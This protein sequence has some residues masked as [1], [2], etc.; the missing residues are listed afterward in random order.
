[1]V[2]GKREEPI[3]VWID[4][5]NIDIDEDFNI[6]M[7]TLF[8]HPMRH[9]FSPISISPTT[10]DFATFP[11][12]DDKAQLLIDTLLDNKPY[13]NSAQILNIQDIK[14]VAVPPVKS[15]SCGVSG[16]PTPKSNRRLRH[17]I[18]IDPVGRDQRRKDKQR[19]YEKGYR[20]RIKTKREKDEAEWI[21]LEAQIRKLL[22]KRTS[23][24]LTEIPDKPNKMSTLSKKQQY[25]QLLQEEN[26]L[27]ESYALE[28]CY[29]ADNKALKLYSGGTGSSRTIREQL[30]SLPS[31]RLC[32][33]FDFS[34]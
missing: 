22:A 32:H 6:F 13:E 31:L 23:I 4:P 27:R 3:P 20:S 17:R 15:K 24:V 19:G 26:A 33:T 7:D 29:L 12:S 8:G 34:W 9:N 2:Q 18:N 1:M 25:F 11:I 28:R 21:Q 5:I 14:V 30:N 16:I 10:E